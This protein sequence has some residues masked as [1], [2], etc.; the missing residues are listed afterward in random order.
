LVSKFGFFV[1][2]GRKLYKVNNEEIR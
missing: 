2:K 1:G